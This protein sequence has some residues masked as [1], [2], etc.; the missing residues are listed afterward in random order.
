MLAPVDG[1]VQ[2][3]NSAVLEDPTLAS[4]DPYG[5]GW[6][7]QVRIPSRDSVRRNLLGGRLARSWSELAERA[8]Q[9]IAAEAPDAALGAVLADGGEPS[10]GLARALAPNSWEEV[11]QRFF[12]LEPDVDTDVLDEES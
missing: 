12:L 3:V 11:V 2:A 9:G 1:E 6:L 4:R 7:M 8:L 10:E 5:R